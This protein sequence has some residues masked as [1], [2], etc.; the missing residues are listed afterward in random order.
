VDGK[1]NAVIIIMTTPE[2]SN[3][4]GAITFSNLLQQCKT[5]AVSSWMIE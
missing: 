1:L 2:E 5:S 3:A 4:T